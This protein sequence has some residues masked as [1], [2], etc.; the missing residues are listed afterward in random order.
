[1][2]RKNLARA[3][4]ALSWSGK[5]GLAL[6]IFWIII[7]LVG[8]FI[9]PYPP[10]AFVSYE[11]FAGATG[12][13]WFG[14]D[15]LGRDVLSRLLVGAQF[16][17]G[18]S[19]VA[20][21][22]AVALGTGFALTAAV[23]P[24]WLDEFLSRAMDT[25]ISIP[26]KIFALVLVAAFGSSIMLL[27]LVVSVTYVPGNFR[28]A[29]SLAIGLTRLDYVEVA[30]ARGE[31][32]LHIALV[33]ILPNMIRPLFADVGLRFVFIVLLLSGLSFLGLGLQPP[34]ADLGSLVR[35]NVNGLG[36]GALAILVPAVAIASLT[37]GVNLLIDAATQG[38]G[39]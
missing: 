37:V 11:V 2:K 18:L 3:I 23:G 27:T 34:N 1:M 32:R 7:A 21:T 17:V 33:E 24:R 35:E 39:R 30:R 6:V 31:G 29:R 20:V 38:K 9:T 15:F 10:G 8:G 19:A 12:K 36:E 25:L 22:I 28:I 5:V 26:S 16:T 13:F 4:R 14:S